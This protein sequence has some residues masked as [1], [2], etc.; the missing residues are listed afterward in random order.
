MDAVSA[1]DPSAISRVFRVLCHSLGHVDC[2]RHARRYVAGLVDGLKRSLL[3]LGWSFDRRP[4]IERLAAA[5]LDGFT[6]H[7]VHGEIEPDRLRA[8]VRV[9]TPRLEHLRE[10]TTIISYTVDAS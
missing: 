2:G 3:F 6:E 7:V 1:H 4:G 5:E 9:Q 8:R 10:M